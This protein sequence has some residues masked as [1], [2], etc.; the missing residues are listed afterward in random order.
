[1]GGAYQL[2]PRDATMLRADHAGPRTTVQC[3]QLLMC[4]RRDDD[5][6]TGRNIPT[7]T[8][9]TRRRCML[10]YQYNDMII[11]DHVKAPRVS[12]CMLYSDCVPAT[13]VF[14]FLHPD[15]KK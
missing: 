8:T 2:Q 1:M 12:R 3:V 15:K 7:V 9:P 6:E 5:T 14:Y 13:D 10:F 4:I 11:E